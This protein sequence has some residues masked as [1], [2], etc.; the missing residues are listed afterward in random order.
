MH[1]LVVVVLVIVAS[2]ACSIEGEREEEGVAY[3]A[4]FVCPTPSPDFFY[5]P[6]DYVCPVNAEGAYQ[7]SWMRPETGGWMC[8]NS[9]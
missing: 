5:S 4:P 9:G 7:Y 3:T 2:A 8:T 6:S 1:P